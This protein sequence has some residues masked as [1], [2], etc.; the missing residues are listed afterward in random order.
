[1]TRTAAREVAVRLNFGLAENP[2]DPGELLSTVFE[3]GYYSTLKTEDKLYFDS[4]D[5]AQLEYITRL[6][7]GVFEHGAEL[8]GYI[9]K[10]AVGWRTWGGA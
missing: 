2:S 4:P 3:D 6:V 7:T 10:Y 1:L 8:D 5:A 9:D